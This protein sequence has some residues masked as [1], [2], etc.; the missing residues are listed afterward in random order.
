MPETRGPWAPL[1]TRLGGGSV[2]PIPRT[3]LSLIQTRL[4]LASSLPSAIAMAPSKIQQGHGR[5]VLRNDGSENVFSELAATYPLKLLSP[6]LPS[7]DVSIIY[8]LSYGGGLVGGD[9]VHLNVEVRDSS[10]LVILSQVSTSS[11][12]YSPPIDHTTNAR[13]LPKCS[14]RG[15]GSVYPLD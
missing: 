6:Q 14:R 10:R 13:D 11:P 8:V 3:Y 5:V 15:R 7:P 2:A 9:R 1:G 4:G 12:M